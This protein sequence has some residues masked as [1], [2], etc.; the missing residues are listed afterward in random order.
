MEEQF[1]KMLELVNKYKVLVDD[2]LLEKAKLVLENSKLKD[3][4]TELKK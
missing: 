1:Y 2:L 3:Q 4:L